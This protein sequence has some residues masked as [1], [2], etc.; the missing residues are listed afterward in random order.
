MDGQVHVRIRNV[1]L[2]VAVCRAGRT[3]TVRLTGA[4]AGSAA[5]AFGGRLWAHGCPRGP[6]SRVSNGGVASGPSERAA[7]T[8]AFE[9]DHLTVPAGKRVVRRP[10]VRNA[11]RA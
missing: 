8:V 2:H 7:R 1:E 11:L 4:P 3:N 6:V 10:G 9:L 5:G